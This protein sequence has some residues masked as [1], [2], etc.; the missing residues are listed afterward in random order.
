MG[1]EDLAGEAETFRAM[2]VELAEL[3]RAKFR[4]WRGRP[5]A[6]WSLDDRR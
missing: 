1:D 5:P 2:L 6:K 3:G 4:D